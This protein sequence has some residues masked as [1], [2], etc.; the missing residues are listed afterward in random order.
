MKKLI[1]SSVLALGL[2]SAAANANVL[3]E[4][5]G[6]KTPTGNSTV[7]YTFTDLGYHES[8]YLNFDLYILDSWDG[9]VS[10]SVGGD[11]FG[12]KVNGMTYEWS[13]RGKTQSYFMNDL[14]SE[15]QSDYVIGDY[16]DVYT[17]GTMDRFYDDFYNGFVIPHTEDELTISFYGR[18]LQAIS[19][20]AWA[21]DDIRIETSEEQRFNGQ[22]SFL[23]SDVSTPFFMSILMFGAA[24]IA[25]RKEK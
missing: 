4:N 14:D 13:F 6:S 22:T 11:F 10:A 7:D 23:L 19:D 9:L 1:K 21:V 18:G 25:R 24:A 12:I 15:I 3:L 8:I 2:I 17:W 16:N 5:G 20:E